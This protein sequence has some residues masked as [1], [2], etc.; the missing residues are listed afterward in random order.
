LISNDDDAFWLKE[1]FASIPQHTSPASNE[2]VLEV[3]LATYRSSIQGL[4][5]YDPGFMDSVN[6]ATTLAGQ[7]D[8][9]VVSP[10]QAERLQASFELLILADLR[11]HKWRSR[12]QAYRWAQ[13]HLLSSASSR[14]VAGMH[15]T[16][17]GGLR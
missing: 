7:R 5:T 13:Q 15:P 14:L 17:A 16:I 1:L 12:L 11:T 9:I 3:L 10:A 2:D 8:G 4:I 6:I